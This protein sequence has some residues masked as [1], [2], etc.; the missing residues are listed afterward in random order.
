[1]SAEIPISPQNSPNSETQAFRSLVP[2]LAW[3]IAHGNPEGV[4]TMSISLCSFAS[5]CSSTIIANV[6]VPA[7]KLPVLG[8]TEF[9]AVIPVPASP[10]GGHTG[11]PA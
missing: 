4:V 7:D 5:L 1:M 6:D 11:T 8:A 10:S 3:D 2:L 9:V